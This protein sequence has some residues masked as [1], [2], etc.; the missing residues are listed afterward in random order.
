MITLP[1]C[2]KE[3]ACPDGGRVLQPILGTD[4]RNPIFSVYRPAGAA[5]GELQVYYGAELLEVVPDDSQHPAFRLL[6]GRLYNAGLKAVT[7]QR[8]FGVDRKSL[9]RW[10]R[11]LCSN[12]PQHLARALAGR[13]G[14]RKFTPEIRAFVTLRF[15]QLYREQRTGYC[16]R[17]RAEIAAVFGVHLSGECLRIP[18]RALKAQ[19]RNE[20]G[21]AAAGLLPEN[22]A[23]TCAE[24]TAAAP[25]TPGGAVPATAR[26]NQSPV[27]A[28]DPRFCRHLG[29]LLFSP[30]LLRLEAVAS[31]GWLLKQ[32]LATLLLGA[33]NIEQTKLLD[34]EDLAS[35]LGRTLRNLFSQRLQLS[36]LA[37]SATVSVVLRCNAA[38]VGAPQCRDFYFDPHTKHYTGQQPILKGWCARIRWADKVLHSDFVHTATGEPVYLECADNYLDLRER[39]ARLRPRL[40]AQ[41]ALPADA[42]ITLVIDRGIFSQAVFAAVIADPTYHL[43][44]W[45][46]NY[47]PGQW[48]TAPPTGECVLER[49]RNRAT[50]KQCYRFAYL[51]RDW[52]KN[53]AMRQLIVRA[54]NP[55]GL[56]AEVGVLTDDRQRPASQIIRLIFNRWIQENDFKYLDEHFGINQIT[57]YASVAYEQLRTQVE[58]K[59]IKSGTYKALEL[60]RTQRKTALSKLLLAEHLHPG[61]SASR[62][63]CLATLTQQLAQVEQRLVQTEREVS[64]LDVLI[65]QKMVR[66]DTRNKR[67]LDGVKLIARNAFYQALAPFKRAYDNFRDDHVW[68][69][70]FTQADGVLV[71]SATHVDAYLLPTAN[72]PPK[73]AKI[74]QDCLTRFNAS[75]PLMP[76][77]SGRS[78]RLHLAKKAGL[79]VAFRSGPKGGIY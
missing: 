4:K 20:V 12:D 35:L 23:T 22:R 8:S 61:R 43:I 65:A 78:L 54:T 69:R 41:L 52:P 1:E 56:T 2:D 53:P 21:A 13:R 79:Q 60:E 63:A 42:V 59:Q 76:D 62:M 45:E 64:R 73:L 44:T 75:A 74:F 30:V 3:E 9:Q 66:L 77:G 16:K 71:A 19:L 25:A 18:L 29:V 34:F 26:R 67:L 58:A 15:A 17:L 47:Q 40:R 24:V 27:F 49:T 28:P 50:D 39:L 36:A 72:Y 57:S 48:T 14:P 33:A 37:A 11:A 5:A 32:W 7:L 55:Q 38:L 70:N 51:D 10:G 46:K 6:L 68:F 31:A